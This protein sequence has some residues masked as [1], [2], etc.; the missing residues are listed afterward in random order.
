MTKSLHLLFQQFFMIGW[1]IGITPEG[2]IVIEG[3]QVTDPYPFQVLYG[4]IKS[5]FLA[6]SNEYKRMH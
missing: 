3:N 5:S 1:D 6:H 4:G 2:P